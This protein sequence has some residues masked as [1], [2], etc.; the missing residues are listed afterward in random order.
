M[1]RKINLPFVF[2]IILLAFLIVNSYITINSE[3]E[4]RREGLEYRKNICKNKEQ[5]CKDYEHG[6]DYCISMCAYVSD[7]DKIDMQDAIYVSFEMLYEDTIRHIFILG[8][9][10]IGVSAIWKFLCDLKSGNYKNKITRIEYKKYIKKSWISS[11]KFTLVFPIFILIIFLIGFMM[12][13]TSSA[14]TFLESFNF[15]ISNNGTTN[16]LGY[17][18]LVFLSFIAMYTFIINLFY[19]CASKAGNIL[20]SIIYSILLYFGIWI[21]S[22]SV[23][24]NLIFHNILGFDYDV[25]SNF[26]FTEIWNLDYNFAPILFVYYILLAGISTFVVFRIY[27]NKEEVIIYND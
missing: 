15:W 7:E 20:L 16:I 9:I 5:N 17:I 2:T 3:Y 4:Y 19:I 27:K 6:Y 13:G 10:L 14:D 1:L 26:G 22:E 8:P 11:L 25:A 24:G 12:R 21:L 23:V 18:L